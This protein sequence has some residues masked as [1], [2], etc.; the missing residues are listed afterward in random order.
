LEEE[1]PVNRKINQLE[2][3]GEDREQENIIVQSDDTKT[4][5]RVNET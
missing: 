3:G 2:M 5:K 1:K 4:Q